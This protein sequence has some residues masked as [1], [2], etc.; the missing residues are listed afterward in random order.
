MDLLKGEIER[1][2]KELEET[3]V[4]GV[5]YLRKIELSYQ[6]FRIAHVIFIL[7]AEKIFQTRRFAANSN[8]KLY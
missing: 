1:K 8:K 5:S 4:L 2:R 3:N 7:V 6:I